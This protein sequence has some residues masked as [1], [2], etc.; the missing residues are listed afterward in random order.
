[1]HPTTLQL[2]LAL[3]A[4]G[5]LVASLACHHA[6]CGAGLPETDDTRSVEQHGMAGV[7]LMTAVTTIFAL[8][9][10]LRCLLPS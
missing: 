7:L 6:L 2:A 5:M 1:M 10:G 3:A 8:S 9:F 4:C